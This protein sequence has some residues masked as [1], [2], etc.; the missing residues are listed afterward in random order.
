M[1]KALNI[2]G[3]NNEARSINRRVYLF[4]EHPLLHN[5]LDKFINT[6]C[7]SGEAKNAKRV[8]GCKTSVHKKRDSYETAICLE[9]GFVKSV[10]EMLKLRK[11]LKKLKMNAESKTKTELIT[12]TLI[13]RF[14]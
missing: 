2:D 9:L 3:V 12:T 11:K 10:F 4:W 1:Q 7:N 8:K 14:L 6:L 5:K 13:I